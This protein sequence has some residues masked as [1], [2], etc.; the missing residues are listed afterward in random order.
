MHSSLEALTTTTNDERT[1]V[2][3]AQVLLFALLW[4]QPALA[5]VDHGHFQYNAVSLGLAVV[6]FACIAHRTQRTTVILGAP[7]PSPCL[8]H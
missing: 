8:G 1:P 3:N 2:A 4:L 6:A 7:F 5:L